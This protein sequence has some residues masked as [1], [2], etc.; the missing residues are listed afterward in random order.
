MA[1][2][3]VHYGGHL[4]NQ[5]TRSLER[6]LEEANLSGELKLSNRTL[7]EFPQIPPEGKYNLSDTVIAGWLPSPLKA[8]VAIYRQQNVEM[9]FVLY[10][11]GR[12]YRFYVEIKPHFCRRYRTGRLLYLFI[13]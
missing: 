12:C 13:L 3:A 4:Q 5:L 11:T 6:I 7:K 1:V 9:R 10:H 8:S 2:S